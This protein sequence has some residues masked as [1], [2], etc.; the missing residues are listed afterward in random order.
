M[1]GQK[2]NNHD[3]PAADPRGRVCHRSFTWL[4]IPGKVQPDGSI[5]PDLVS[6][7]PRRRIMRM[8]SPCIGEG[9]ML[10]DAANARAGTRSGSGP[11]RL[12]LTGTGWSR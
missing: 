5:E 7:P 1:S 12:W 6:G 11:L 3:V 9:C 10:W 2:R 8:Q 4:V